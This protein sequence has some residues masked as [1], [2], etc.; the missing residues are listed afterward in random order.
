MGSQ[1]AADQQVPM[2][3]MRQALQGDAHTGLAHWAGQSDL[4]PASEFQISLPL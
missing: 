4:F 1:A 2:G 3:A